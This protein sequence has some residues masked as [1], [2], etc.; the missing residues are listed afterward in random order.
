M[1]SANTLR[2]KVHGSEL[3]GLLPLPHSCFLKEVNRFCFLC[4]QVFSKLFWE[5]N[6]F[7]P[8]RRTCCS[9][10]TQ[11][12]LLC[13]EETSW[14]TEGNHRMNEDLFRRLNTAHSS[15]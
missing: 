14:L 11:S 8:R 15:Y 5:N 4:V 3:I 12:P 13:I 10:E 1:D 7:Q 2:R 6:L 9:I